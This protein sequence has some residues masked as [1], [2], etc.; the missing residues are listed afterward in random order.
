MTLTRFE[1]ANAFLLAL[2]PETEDQVRKIISEIPDSHL[3]YIRRGAERL[4]QMIRV[5]EGNR[6]WGETG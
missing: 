3:V 6:A 5:E 1:E 4:A 2:E